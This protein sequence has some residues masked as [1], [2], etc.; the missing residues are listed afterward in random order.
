MTIWQYLNFCNPKLQNF[1]CLTPYSSLQWFTGDELG[2]LLIH[3][4]NWP[5]FLGVRFLWLVK[6]QKYF[7]EN[8]L[9]PGKG[10]SRIFLSIKFVW[11]NWPPSPN[12]VLM[13]QITSAVD[14]FWRQNFFSAWFFEKR[15]NKLK[16]DF[17][18]LTPWYLVT[19]SWI[20][21]NQVLALRKW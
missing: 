12:N 5:K 16:S 7:V 1:A 17:I 21:G 11:S 15:E 13:S 20:L 9:Y 14:R 18:R 3:G 2:K 19:K 10:H 4:P 6:A 8:N